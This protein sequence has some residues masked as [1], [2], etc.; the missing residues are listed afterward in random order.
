MKSLAALYAFAL[1]SF[2]LWDHSIGRT[3]LLSM[4][5]LFED[6]TFRVQVHES[7]P[8][9]RELTF[10]CTRGCEQ[11]V[12][13]REAVHG[14]PLGVLRTSDAN[15]FVLT[16]WGSATSIIVRVYARE[17]ARFRKVLER[18]SVKG[19]VISEDNAGMPR[20]TTY[21]RD[22]DGAGAH[23][24]IKSRTWTWATGKFISGY[25]L[26]AVNP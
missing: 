9:D 24:K 5:L 18:H 2:S 19:P 1:L 11:E 6:T 10:K 13:V 25:D 3:V 21:E 14:Y 15:D 7:A 4:E 22:N 16:T 23:R 26:D 8:L 17:G 12:E 20:I